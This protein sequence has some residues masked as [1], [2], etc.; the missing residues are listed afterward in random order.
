MSYGYRL[1]YT[2]ICI[3]L[4]EVSRLNQWQICALK[5]MRKCYCTI[6]G[7]LLNVMWQP[8]W[9]GSLGENRYMYMYG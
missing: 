8:G 5:K 6:H 7:T 2:G 4:S 1:N 9:E 3:I